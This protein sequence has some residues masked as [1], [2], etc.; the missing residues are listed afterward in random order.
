VTKGSHSVMNHS[1][2]IQEPAEPVVVT[3]DRRQGIINSSPKDFSNLQTNTECSEIGRL[4]FTLSSAGTVIFVLLICL[5]F[6]L[7]LQLGHN[8]HITGRHSKFLIVFSLPTENV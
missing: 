7:S 1:S 3:R 6:K 5:V 4:Y 8:E 2:I